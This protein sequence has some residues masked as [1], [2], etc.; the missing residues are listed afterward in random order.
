MT[1]RRRLRLPPLAEVRKALALPAATVVGVVDHWA[2]TGEL[3]AG[4]GRL[5][6][7]AFAGA[8]IVWA[9]PN[10]AAAPR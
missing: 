4:H 2:L 1:Q 10:D 9:V 8:L 7:A 5:I 6:L 3:T